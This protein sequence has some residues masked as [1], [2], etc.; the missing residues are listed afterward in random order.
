MR[1]TAVSKGGHKPSSLPPFETPAFGGLLR[2]TVE[3]VAALGKDFKMMAL[4]LKTSFA[5]LLITLVVFA[6]A[7]FAQSYPNRPVR[8]LLPYNPGGIVD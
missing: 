2:V 6:G 7:A 4:K 1:S 8:L 5:G 3:L